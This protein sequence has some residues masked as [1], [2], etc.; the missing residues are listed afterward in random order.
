M[1]LID[2]QMPEGCKDCPC[3]EKSL[4]GKCNLKKEWLSVQDNNKRPG[5]CPLK[6]I[7]LCKDCANFNIK[8]KICVHM[9]V[10]TEGNGYCSDWKRRTD[11]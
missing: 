6:E 8:N 4:Y 5:W 1:I 10:N 11:E 7:R 3:Y 9:G 2:V